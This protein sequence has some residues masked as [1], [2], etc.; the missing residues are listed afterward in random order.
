MKRALSV[1]QYVA[2]V[3]LAPLSFLLWRREYGGNLKLI[4]AAWLVPVLWAYIVPGIGTIDGCCASSHAKA[5]CA[6]VACL[7]VANAFSQS[8]N[9]RFALR[10]S[11]VNRRRL[12][13][14]PDHLRAP[15]LFENRPQRLVE[16][17]AIFQERL[18]QHAFLDRAHLAKRV[19]RFGDR[20]GRVR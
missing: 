10:L 11:S 8:T 17:F 2:P 15:I 19:R 20:A 13:G 4:A 5:I 3:V 14:G 18:P 1:Y 9:A 6:G 12:L 7:R 16:V